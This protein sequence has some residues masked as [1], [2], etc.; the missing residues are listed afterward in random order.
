MALL[1][2]TAC[3]PVP[4]TTTDGNGQI[5]QGDTSLLKMLYWQAPTILNPHLSTGFKDWE[6]S[7]ITL[8]PLATFNENSELIPV[9]AAEIPSVENGGVSG[10]GLSVTWKLKQGVQWSDGQPFTAADVVFTH[11]LLANPDAGATTLG[12]MSAIAKVEALD[13]YTVKITFKEVTPAW[14]GVFVGAEGIV[15]PR[16]VFKDYTGTKF[17]TAPGNLLPIGTGAYRVVEFKPGDVVLYE[18]NPHYRDLKG[19][20]FERIE[21]KG[22]GDAVSAARAVLQTGDADFAYNLQ[23]EAKILE[24]LSQGGQGK[25]LANFG[26]LSERILFNFTDPNRETAAGERSSVDFPH[27]FF[28]DRRVREAIA[29]AVDRDTITAQLY[30]VT[31]KTT[32]NFIVNPPEYV[33][34]NTRYEFNLDKAQKL[35]DEAGW[36]DSNG[37]GTRDKNGVEMKIL[38]QTSVNPLRQKVQAIAKQTLGQIGIDVEL[39]SIDAS[40]Y[41]S[42]DPANTDTTERFTADLQMFTTGNTNPDPLPYL[43]SYTCEQ[44]PSKAN[45]WTGDN[46]SRYCDRQFDAL[47]TAATKELD[48]TKR[49]AAFIAMNDQLVNNFIVLPLV[50]RAETPGVSNHLSGVSL[51]PWDMNTWNIATWRK[52]N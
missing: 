38:F 28:S 19:L 27:P 3:N 42:G 1:G 21:L 5:T 4:P 15:L 14:F 13:D 25:A 7:R 49:Q 22:G 50:H 36:V 16:H 44:I 17:R 18:K 35:L 46:Y 6:A 43:K 9:L 32:S 2:L 20:A 30:G 12:V 48:P 23:V 34:Q 29:L 41:F 10:D 51:T 37:D 39:K 31:G 8:E 52:T 11:E 45:N 26:S 40:V 24:E 47:W 33:S